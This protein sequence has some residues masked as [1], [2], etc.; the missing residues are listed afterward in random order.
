MFLDQKGKYPFP[1][2]T[3]I[4]L[5]SI[6]N[7]LQIVDRFVEPIGNSEI[8]DICSEVKEWYNPLIQLDQFRYSYLMN[9]GITQGLETLGLMYK[10][11]HLLQGD[12]FWLKTI[13][14]GLEVNEKVPCEISYASCPSAVDGNVVNTTWPSKMHILDGAYIGTSLTKTPIPENTEIVLLGFS[15]NLGI[16]ELRSGIIFSKKPIQHLEI[17]QKTFGYVGPGVFRSA[18]KICRDM[19]ITSLAETLKHYQEK[20]C[21]LHTELIPSDSA[22]LATTEDLSYN[23]YKRPNGIMRVPL[24]ESITTSIENSLI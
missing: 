9:N 16:P 3:P 1:K 7:Q 24:G 12:Y 2:V 14:A 23:F 4:R 11:I 6:I 5:P 15:K 18:L 10:N 13:K 17:F 20:F 22:L 8:N 21:K 19:S